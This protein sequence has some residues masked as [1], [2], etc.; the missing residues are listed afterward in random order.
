MW[1]SIGCDCAGK[2]TVKMVQI[3]WN[4][5]AVNALKYAHNPILRWTTHGTN[6]S[7]AASIRNGIANRIEENIH[8]ATY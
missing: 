3:W 5:T 4:M 7:T 6:V 1:I 8:F 2:H